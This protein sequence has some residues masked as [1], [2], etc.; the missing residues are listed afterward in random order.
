M[1]D[2][3][4]VLLQSKI[5]EIKIMQSILS[6]EE[7]L[8]K[9]LKVVSTVKKL[10]RLS[11]EW[12][13][14]LN[15]KYGGSWMEEVILTPYFVSGMKDYDGLCFVLSLY[16]VTAI[17]EKENSRII[18]AKMLAMLP[19]Q[20]KELYEKESR[21]EDLYSKYAKRAKELKCEYDEKDEKFAIF[22]IVDDV[23]L[24]MEE[25]TLMQFLRDSSNESIMMILR[26]VGEKSARRIF[27]NFSMRLGE[28]ML[29]DME[30]QGEINA[31]LIAERLPNI[32][33]T[34]FEKMLEDPE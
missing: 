6:E 19:K 25:R 13:H 26:V 18:K 29:E 17:K 7:R 12:K 23:I 20:I 21:D 10:L 24:R 8:E 5:E 14:G 30:E 27:S 22:K 1:R 33:G 28:M 15:E 34:V 31:E 3:I 9:E 11:S 4:P 2:T 16:L 32:I